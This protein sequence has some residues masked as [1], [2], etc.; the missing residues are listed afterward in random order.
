MF[1]KADYN[2]VFFVAA[3]LVM[4]FIGG[5]LTTVAPPLI[6][7]SWTTPF[8][9]NDTGNGPTG[10]L[11]Q[12]NEQEQKGRAI[13]I[14]EGCW[15]CH[16][17]QVRTLLADTKRYGWRGV[18]APISTPDEFVYDN[19]HM[20]GTKRTGPDLARVGGKYN[21]QWHKAHF[22][23]PADLVPGSI[24]PPFPWIANNPEELDALVAYMQTLGRAK[25]WRPDND[26][27]K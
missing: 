26:Y 17:Q 23:N 24:M 16:T 12:L 19:P 9:N 11:V 14:R 2:A 5:L 7:Q 20:F 15:Y 25:N 3:A 6:D 4:F 18:D 10:K 8:E 21:A 13:Y 22:R 1:Q 27:E